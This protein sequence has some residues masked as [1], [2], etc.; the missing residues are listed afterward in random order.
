MQTSYIYYL[1]KS[2]NVLKHQIKIQHCEEF[3]GKVLHHGYLPFP[4][5]TTKDAQNLTRIP[6]EDM[7]H[8]CVYLNTTTYLSLVY[9]IL[10][11][12]EVSAGNLTNFDDL[13]KILFDRLQNAGEEYRKKHS[14]DLLTALDKN[15]SDVEEARSCFANSVVV[16]P[17]G[18]S[19][20]DISF[21]TF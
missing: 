3:V 20:Y 6:N 2:T 5:Q 18:K 4:L 15:Y 16:F 11:L 17:P 9:S 14:E 10:L 8:I 19:V 12:F 21:K 13:K 1:N 7:I